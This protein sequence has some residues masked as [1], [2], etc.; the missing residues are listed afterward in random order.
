M[1]KGGEEKSAQS[2]PQCC[3]DSNIGIDEL[4]L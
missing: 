2:F 4:E 1:R 3:T